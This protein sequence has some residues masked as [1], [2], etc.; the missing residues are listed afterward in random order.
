M[1]K[2][3]S[4]RKTALSVIIASTTFL[5][6]F[7]AGLNEWFPYPVLREAKMKLD[8]KSTSKFAFAKLALREDVLAADPDRKVVDCPN[9]DDRVGVVLAFGQSNSAN[10]AQHLYKPRDVPDVVN[11][12]DG[13]CYEAK[14]PLIGATGAYGEWISRAAQGL[15]DLGT[16]DRVVVVSLGVG[17][18][19]IA[20][21]TPGGALNARLV[22]QL[23]LL[24]DAYAVT[25]MIWHQGETDANWGMGTMQYVRSFD[26]LYASVKDTGVDAPLF[27]SIASYC[28]GGDYPNPITDAQHQIAETMDSV[29]LGVNT[30]ELVTPSMRPDRCHFGK[31][32]Q[33]AAARELAAIIA[34]HHAET[35]AMK[36]D[37]VGN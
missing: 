9:Q 33:E 26:A 3:I 28:R 31:E 22:E 15:V 17:G 36:M 34:N 8:G 12:Y 23:R 5:Y 21:W 19:P 13:V 4:A 11:W 2:A 18:S 29:V 6:G 20:A 30:D 27:M 32:G 1:L 37:A 10:S 7:T 14:S 35:Y 24:N 16:Y 25:D